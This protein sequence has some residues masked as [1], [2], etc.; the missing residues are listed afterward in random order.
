VIALAALLLALAVFI[1]IPA[2]PEPRLQRLSRVEERSRRSLTPAQLGLGAAIL[3]GLGAVGL[4]GPLPG[5]VIAVLAFVLMPRL[6]S[7]LESGE[8]RRQRQALERQLPDALD[9]L[10]SV[11]EAGA[12]PGD[13]LAAVGEAL[14]P[15]ISAELLRVTRAL[16]LGAT[17]Q[18]AWS[19]AHSTMRPLATAMC[20]SA[21]SGAPL[22]LVLAG[23]SRDARREHRVRVEVAARSAGVRAV[24]PLAACFLPAFFLLGVAPIVASFVEQLLH[25]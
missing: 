8:S 25:S 14:G 13:A 18:Q 22:A 17:A 2:R 12:P 20:R 19:S 11:L 15:P 10:T 24:A 9:V 16:D 1:W 6:M 23:A 7:R 21:E 4:L 5:L 3:V